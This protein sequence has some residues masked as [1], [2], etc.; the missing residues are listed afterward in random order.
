MRRWTAGLLLAAASAACLVSI[1][2][3]K[4]GAKNDGGADAPPSPDT[5]DAST[6]ADAADAS[7]GVPADAGLIGSWSFEEEGG[8]A[9]DSSGHGNDAE[10][11]LVTERFPGLRG[12]GVELNVVVSDSRQFF[13][14][15]KL[16]GPSFPKTGTL[17]FWYREAP[18]ASGVGDLLDISPVGQR[19]TIFGQ[20]DLEVDGGAAETVTF[21]FWGNGVDTAQVSQPSKPMEWNHVVLVWGDRASGTTL[22]VGPLGQGL[23]SRHVDYAQ[24]FVPSDQ[25]LVI[26]KGVVAY[27][28]EVRLFDRPLGDAEVRSIE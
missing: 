21:A 20:V 22:Y 25:K 7:N 24:D 11:V 2:D 8:T 1:D 6:A 13:Q 12:N 18:T 26:G 4:V 23:S 17:A 27:L 16:D 10:L 15:A 5:G 28:D 19:A 14:V 3:S 9:F